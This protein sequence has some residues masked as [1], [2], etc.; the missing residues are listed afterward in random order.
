MSAVFKFALLGYGYI[1]AICFGCAALCIIYR[2]APKWLRRTLTALILIGAAVFAVIEIPIIKAARTDAPEGCRYI[3]VLGAGVNGTRPSLSLSTRLDGALEYLEANPDTLAIVSGGQG[4]G[5]DITEAEC[6]RL[7]LEERGI[8]PERIIKEDRST[9][10]LENLSNSFAIIR[11]RGDEPEGAAV[12]SSMYHLYRAKLLAESLG[13]R[14]YGI[15][16]PIG[17]VL[18]TVN[19]FIREGFGRI[20]YWVFGIQ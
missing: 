1:A 13:V 3:I 17:Y 11:A 9:N 20:Y 12:V 2:F 5:E 6:M 16:A 10:T 15:A 7:Y 14:V 19:Y 8:D 18:V 4:E